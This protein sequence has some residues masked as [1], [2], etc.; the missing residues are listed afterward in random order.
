MTNAEVKDF[1]DSTLVS[2]HGNDLLR[3]PQR[4]GYEAIVSHFEDEEGPCYVQLP[5]GCGKTGLMGIAPFGVS[6][7]R[8]LIVA[9]N[10]TVRD[11]MCPSGRPEKSLN[12]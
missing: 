4:E 5:V 9:P 6:P 10:L 8:V 2:I 1:F 12:L 7:G 3:E 11:T